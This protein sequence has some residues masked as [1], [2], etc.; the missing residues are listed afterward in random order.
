MKFTDKIWHKIRAGTGVII[1][2]VGM[3]IMEVMGR[4]CT[5]TTTTTSTTTTATMDQEAMVTDKVAIL[6]AITTATIIMVQI[7]VTDREVRIIGGWVDQVGRVHR[8]IGMGVCRDLVGRMGRVVVNRSVVTDQT[9]KD[10]T[11]D[12][13]AAEDE[14]PSKK[15]NFIYK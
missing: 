2:M 5:T 12:K 14:Q 8:V 4:I 9:T 13:V 11:A 10:P 15:P 1:V 6:A 3:G 7:M